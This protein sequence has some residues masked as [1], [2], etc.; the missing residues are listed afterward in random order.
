MKMTPV[1]PAN[2]FTDDIDKKGTV[3]HIIGDTLNYDYMF[4][5]PPL[6]VE[7]P[8]STLQVD[9]HW[10]PPLENRALCFC[11]PSEPMH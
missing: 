8:I 7:M 9:P 10:G 11:P 2:E 6:G 3:V 1:L 4:L 5:R